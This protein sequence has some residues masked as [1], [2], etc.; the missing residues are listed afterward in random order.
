MVLITLYA[1]NV[2]ILA[3]TVMDL[4]HVYRVQTQNIEFLQL[5]V[6]V[7]LDILIMELFVK[8]NPI[9]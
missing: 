2:I 7:Y 4:L 6:T 1:N 3:K 5:I 9:L 8:V